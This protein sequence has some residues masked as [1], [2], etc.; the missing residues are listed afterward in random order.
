MVEVRHNPIKATTTIP[1][2]LMHRLVTSEKREIGMLVW[3]PSYS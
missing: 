3:P 1:V 2:S